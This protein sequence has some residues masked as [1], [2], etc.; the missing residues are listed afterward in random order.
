MDAD[1]I[2]VGGG[3]AGMVAAA[4]SAVAGRRA[5]VLEQGGDE[6]YLC[7]S[8]LTGGIFHLAYHSV[9]DDAASIIAAIEDGTGRK[10]DPLLASVVTDAKRAVAWLQSVGIRY[11]RGNAT[12]HSHVLAPPPPPQLGRPWQGR[13]GDVALRT[14]EGV[15]RARGGEVR[16]GHRVDALIREGGRVTGVQ[17]LGPDGRSFALRAQAVVIA[18]G[19]FQANLDEI[20]TH[21]TPAPSEVVQ[22]N[23][24]SGRGDGLRIALAAGA[25]ATSRDCFYGHLLC[26]DALTNDQLW[27]YPYLDEIARVAIVVGPDGRRVADEGRGGVYLANAIARLAHPA[28]TTLVFDQA[29]W[30]G[31]ARVRAIPPNPILAKAGGTVRS[32]STLQA[33]AAAGQLPADALQQQVAAFNGAIEAGTLGALDPPRSTHKYAPMPIARPPFYA[34]PLAPGITYTMG[35]IR[36]D[37][38]SR[39]LDDQGRPV[40][41]LYAAGSATGGIEGGAH[42]GYAGGLACAA[43]T[44]LHAAEHLSGVVAA[45]P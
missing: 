9:L 36:I 26:R 34:I 37:V 21:V 5:L 38:H 11:V 28:S 19:G 20:A 31:P 40:P 23:A 18:D 4:R 39:A 22:R 35:G 24:G 1:V 8:R 7:N 25:A 15:L 44:A 16:R 41:G 12:W 13:G 3:I 17:A 45:D 29:A 42:A 33:L 14:L 30:D 6:R 27:P 43:T 32:A 10:N 2:V